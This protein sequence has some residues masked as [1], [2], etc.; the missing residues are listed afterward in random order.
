MSQNCPPSYD[1]M[2]ASG[3]IE[4]DRRIANRR[5]A[6]RRSGQGAI[7]IYKYQFAAEYGVW[8]DN[9][10]TFVTVNDA[11]ESANHLTTRWLGKTTWHIVNRFTKEVVQTKENWLVEMNEKWLTK[12]NQEKT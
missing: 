1:E 10:L 9:S 6:E 5:K 7:D 4:E 2:V 3:H 12:R 8:M 11:I